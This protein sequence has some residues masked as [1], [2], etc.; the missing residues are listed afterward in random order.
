MK[1]A[2]PQLLFGS[3]HRIRTQ[4]TWKSSNVQWSDCPVDVKLVRHGLRAPSP[5]L[6]RHAHTMP[7]VPASHCLPLPHQS[8]ARG[9]TGATLPMSRALSAMR[10]SERAASRSVREASTS[11]LRRPPKTCTTQ[12]HSQCPSCTYGIA[13]IGMRNTGHTFHLTHGRGRLHEVDL[14]SARCIHAQALGRAL[15]ALGV[16]DGRRGCLQHATTIINEVTCCE[17][18]SAALWGP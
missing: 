13:V 3:P 15:A 16:D 18:Q 8:I 5:P 9:F 12:P 17:P 1:P 10:I 11:A 6:V 2:A 14:G 7:L 4:L